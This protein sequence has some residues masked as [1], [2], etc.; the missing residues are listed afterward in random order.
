MAKSVVP[1]MVCVPL[2]VK[3]PVMTT[4]PPTFKFLAI[5]V[6]PDMTR[7]PSLTVVDCVALVTVVNPL[8][9]SVVNAAVPGVALPMAVICADV[10]VMFLATPR[11]PK[12]T[13][14][15]VSILAESV[16]LAPTM[17]PVNVVTPEIFKLLLIVVEPVPAPMLTVVALRPMF[18]VVTV[19]LNR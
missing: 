3:L 1:I 8:A 2:T 4:L 9:V 13:I 19:S 6:P 5:P 16:V 11:P 15:P 10:A 17:F 14:D 12:V 7:A 18:N